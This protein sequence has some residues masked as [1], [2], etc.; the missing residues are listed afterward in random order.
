MG[1]KDPKA[2]L[3]VLGNL[4]KALSGHIAV[5]KGSAH[6]TGVDTWFTKEVALGDS[7]LIGDRVFLVKEIRGNKELI[8]NAPHPVG[9]FNATVY[10]DS[11]L[12]SVRTGAEVSALSIDKSGNVGV[13]TARPATKLAVAGGVKVGHETRCDAAREGTIRYNNISD[14][15]EFC[16]GRTWSR[17]EG[18]VGAQGKQGDTGPRGPQGPKGDIG[19]QGLK[20]DKGNPGLGG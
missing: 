15:P 5:A 4:S 7:L 6:V 12:L 8:L 13:G 1:I 18:P 16:N 11:D 14:E 9:A 19:P 20:G 10:T 17:V 2:D 3:A